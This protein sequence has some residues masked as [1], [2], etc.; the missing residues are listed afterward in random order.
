[1]KSGFVFPIRSRQGVFSHQGLRKA[2]ADNPV[3]TGL[4]GVAGIAVSAYNYTYVHRGFSFEICVMDALMSLEEGK[5]TILIG[6]IDEHTP[7]YVE[8][9][10]KANK[11][12][13]YTA[14]NRRSSGARQVPGA[15][16]WLASETSRGLDPDG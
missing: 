3:I 6:G 7:I 16:V 14:G 11:L 15:D 13:V 1:M 9:N 8:L 10:R 2:S 5:K 4:G 12:R